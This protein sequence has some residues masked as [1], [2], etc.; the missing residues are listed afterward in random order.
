M[1]E[2]IGGQRVRDKRAFFNVSVDGLLALADHPH[3]RTEV[4]EWA[5]RF[6]K[7]SSRLAYSFMAIC[8]DLL[9]R[10]SEKDFREIVERA[11]LLDRDIDLATTFMDYTPAV[12]AQRDLEYLR[13]WYEGAHGLASVDWWASRGFLESAGKAARWLSADDLPVLAT[14]GGEVAARSRHAAKGLFRAIPALMASMTVPQLTEWVRLG[15]E[16]TS[17]EEDLVLFMSYGSKRSHEAVEVLCRSTSFSAF[18]GRISLMLE[19]FL[20]RPAI[21]RSIY[22]LLDPAKVPPDGRPPE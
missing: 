4:H 20:G 7:R 21:V 16:I 17:R 2:H 10:V 22:D 6:T 13:A 18:R 11:A 9:G 5:H 1:A 15:L 8:R 19:A 3:L 12:L 14:L